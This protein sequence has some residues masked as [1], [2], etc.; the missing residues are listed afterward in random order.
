MGALLD[1]PRVLGRRRHISDRNAF[2]Q[3]IVDF[4]VQDRA[5]G[6]IL[7]L[8]E[9]DDHTHVPA[10][11]RARDAMT[12]AAGYRTIRISALTRPHH[13]AVRSAVAVL[14]PASR[15]PVAA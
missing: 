2:S 5:S 14:L 1:A 7:A 6:R 15:A 10:H 3:K 12:S 8:I 4:V 9:I 13:D 11:D